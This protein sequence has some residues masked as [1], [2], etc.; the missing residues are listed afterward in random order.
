MPVPAIVYIN[1]DRAAERR[2]LMEV[3]AKSLGLAL[4]RF[5]AV[6]AGAVDDATFRR[7]STRWER[8]M[9]RP[10]LA[11]FLSH[12]TLWRRAAEAAAGLIVLE[13]DTIFS[14]H[15]AEAAA[16]V[17]DSGYDLVNFET[18][19]RRKFFSKRPPTRFGGFR[20]T[21]VAREK[22]GAGAYYL[23]QA[24]ARRLLERADRRAAPVDAYMFGVCRLTIAQVEPAATMQVHLLAE[25]GFEV[26][27]STTTSIHQP[28]QP[29]APVMDNLPYLWRRQATQFRLGLVQ[30][31]RL[32][33]VDFRRA[34]FDAAAFEQLLPIS[35]AALDAEMRR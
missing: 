3:Q 14:T 13:D 9:T 8:P 27:L 25:R 4:Q 35:R 22:S 26:G 18:V 1:L 23:S 24:G 12:R 32:A 11:A 5:A 15:F 2:A 21:P 30:L 16:R 7:L 6:E 29:L 34:A 28:R 33:D 19:D 17:A 20:L 31:R 10:E